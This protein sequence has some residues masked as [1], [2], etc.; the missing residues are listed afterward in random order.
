MGPSCRFRRAMVVALLGVVV[1]AAPSLAVAHPLGLT[2]RGEVASAVTPVTDV[3]FSTAA[4][5][6][7][8]VA[9]SGG[10]V[11]R[12]STQPVTF[13]VSPAMT[14]GSFALWLKNTATN[15]L[16]RITPVATPIAAVPA[17][18]TYTVSWK[19]TQAV[20]SYRLL[21]NYYA[22]DGLTVL[23]SAQSADPLLIALAPQPLDIAPA[24]GSVTRGSQQRVSWRMPSPGV[25]S[26]GFAL[27]LKNAATNALTRVTPVAGLI[28]AQA[29][30]TS[31]E[32]TW[33]ASQAAADYYLVVNYYASDR[34][35]QLS[36]GQAAGAVTVLPY[37]AASE[38]SP[39]SGSIARGS[40][41]KVTW[42]M[43]ATT[44]SGFCRLYLKN[45]AT[46]ALTLVTPTASPVTIVPGQASY[47][48]T[49][50]V[51]QAAADYRLQVSYYAAGTST[52]LSSTL[53]T[54]TVTVAPPPQPTLTAP[55]DTAV[56]K[57]SPQTVTWSVPSPGASAGFYALFLKNAA[58]SALT[59]LTPTTSLIPAT[60]GQTSYE[61][62]WTATQ[63]LGASYYLVVYYYAADRV[64]V[65]TT[66][67]SANAYTLIAPTVTAPTG[68]VARGTT[69]SVTWTLPGSGT[70]AGSFRVALK[71]AATNGVTL[72][73]S[74]ANAVKAT[75]R[76]TSYSAPWPVT[77]ALGSSYYLLVYYYAANGTTLLCTGQSAAPVT[78]AATSGPTHVSGTIS[79]DTTWTSAGSPYIVDGA[80]SVE[81]SVT[82]TLAPGTVVKFA[83]SSSGGSGGLELMP[84]ARLVA[85]GTAAAKVYLTSTLD[86][87]VGGDTDGEAVDPAGKGWRGIGLRDRSSVELAYTVVRYSAGFGNRELIWY[88]PAGSSDGR[89][90]PSCV[91]HHCE[92]AGNSGIT[93]G[94]G[95]MGSWPYRFDL[96]Q[97]DA[98]SIHDNQGGI[99]CP[100]GVTTL[101]CTD[102][103]FRDNTETA[104]SAIACGT[105]TVS[106]CRFEGNGTVSGPGAAALQL[107][108][109][110]DLTSASLSGN[111][112]TGNGMAASI[113]AV[114]LPDW[115]DNTVS[116]IGRSNAVELTQGTV[117]AD[118]TLTADHPWVVAT[119]S[120]VRYGT[121]AVAEGVTLT[122][123]PGTVVKFASSSSGGSGGLELMPGA[124]LVAAGTAAA[125][126]YLTST[127]DDSVGGDTDGEAVDPAGKGWRGIG[128]RDRSSV[129][130]AYTVVRYSAGFGNRELIWYGPAGSSDGRPGP[131]CVFHHCEFAGNSGITS[132]GG[133]MGSW[134]YRFDLV[135]L[136]ACSIHDNQ[137]GIS[138]PGGVTTLSCTDSVFRDN[139]ETALSAIACGTATVSGCRFEGNGTALDFSQ[140]WIAAIVFGN[141]IVGN[142]F[143]IRSGGYDPL[144]VAKNNWWGTDS[145]P[146][147]WG[148][149]NGISW[150]VEYDSWRRAYA[151][152][153][154]DVDPWIGKS[155]AVMPNFGRV[156]W[157][158]YA[159]DPVNV[160]IGNYTYTASDVSIRTRGLP[161]E[162]L[163][164][165]NS[166]M[167]QD[168]P[169]GYGWAFSYGQRLLVDEAAEVVV[170]VREDGRELTY[171]DD[172]DGT[173]TPPAGVFDTLIQH[174]DGSYALT[175]KEQ[176]LFAF[177]R[178]GVLTSMRDR[179]G[180]E[181]SLTYN[182]DGH[183]TAV[184]APD[185]RTL[186]LAHDNAG[187]VTSVT[188][189]LGRVWA[190]AYSAAGDLESVTDPMGGLTQ[191]DYDVSHRLLSLTDANG[192]VVVTNTY[193]ANGRV[194]TQGD[195]RGEATTYTYDLGTR[196]TYVRDALGGTTSYVYD[197]E[198][199]VVSKT[200]PLGATTTTDYN[201]Q[202]L[203]TKLTDA[204]G[205]ATRYAYDD[206][207]NLVST[208][209]AAGDTAFATYN[210]T[211]DPLT[212]TDFI[213]YSW[214]FDYDS[215]G[216][217]T[218][219]TDQLGRSA[220]FTYNNEGEA[221][222]STDSLG[223]TTSY[224]W[225]VSG[226][227]LS[228]LTPL[229]ARTG[230]AY[231]AAGRCTA[232]TDPTGEVW[233]N[234]YDANDRLTST[235]D[236]L[237]N[238]T[239][240]AYDA[241]GNCIASTDAMG[242][243]TRYAYDERNDVVKVTDALSAETGY[244]YDA[245][246]RLCC[247]T[248]ANTDTTVYAYDADGRRTSATDPL[249][250]AYSTEYDPAGN[251]TTI[252]DAMGRTTRYSYDSLDHVTT[253]DKPGETEVSF[254]YDADGRKLTTTDARGT[255]IRS[256][257]AMG[258]L[259]AVAA[260][261]G[262]TISYEY[263][264]VGERSSL[265]YPDGRQTHY[266]FDDD[267]RLISAR[268]PSGDDTT[269]TYRT[270]GSLLNQVLPNGVN[271]SYDY[272]SAGRL[273][274]IV[275]Q[276]GT[277]TLLA[278]EYTRD[279][280]G[281]PTV[282]GDSRIGETDYAYDAA[283]RLISES[284][285]SDSTVYGY[286]S[287]GHRL[288]KTVGGV[289][290]SST[291]D[292]AGELL[293]SGAASYVYDANGSRTSRSGGSGDATYGYNSDGLLD[294]LSYEG[295]SESYIYD[296]ENR[297][298]ATLEGDK[299]TGFVLDEGTNPYAV[300]VE[301]AGSSSVTY[302]Y[303]LGLVSQ[304]TSGSVRYFLTDG[305]GSVRLVT[306][307]NG[308]VTADYAYDAF[309][310]ELSGQD[311][312]AY[313]YRYTG[314]S[315]ERGELTYLRARFYEPET[316]L[317][318]SADPLS[319]AGGSTGVYSY[320]GNSPLSAVD[321]T[322]LMTWREYGRS[323][324]NYNNDVELIQG[325]PAIDRAIGIDSAM[326]DIA[327][328]YIDQIEYVHRDP[329]PSRQAMR[330]IENF[331]GAVTT[332]AGGADPTGAIGQLR[333]HPFTDNAYS[334]QGGYLDTISAA[335]TY[336]GDIIGWLWGPEMNAFLGDSSG[337]R[338]AST[339]EP[340]HFQP[341]VIGKPFFYIGQK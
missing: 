308:A 212:R 74:A 237:G 7:T 66:A 116:G 108:S 160:T 181:T 105:A 119:N 20:G 211:N 286:D 265:T 209:N 201:D 168:S 298:V 264:S 9:P 21:V 31:Y 247:V 336:D 242:G 126:V 147:P 258:H 254:T 331:A 15:A 307:E 42:K 299:R 233:S 22:A 37:P 109:T 252:T 124:R 208:T 334:G 245:L 30:Q 26:G 337:R 59:R 77:Q 83:S 113:D 89:P 118:V 146:E 204:S 267:G 198:H 197:A 102:S 5:Q 338:G 269:Y 289:T 221:L 283:G 320:C 97:L 13:S 80:V 131:S 230:Y 184:C 192:H 249:G 87:S 48:T 295:L 140:S 62:T 185:G 335:G 130:L 149:S 296:G 316:G 243:T 326:M 250:R 238:T 78:V 8:L 99:S 257:D 179:H 306:D 297:R 47:E 43:P 268:G 330:A 18:T 203:K 69:Q 218:R 256:Y 28:P 324:R 189:V 172:G 246:R 51:T 263:D 40:V 58:T 281:N 46:N 291:Y 94:G 259:I 173:F 293:T 91:F 79:S 248:D 143:G 23:A 194:A 61:S 96:V 14:S 104:L 294:F 169:F 303:G 54:G 141:K 106:G 41:Q 164:S 333:N 282:I 93:S 121:V 73:T 151:V 202:N 152:L 16:T 85:A 95:G 187:H 171:A 304:E 84:G 82:L 6:L 75:E 32:T 24:G 111:T 35:T 134:P 273:T 210:S 120:Y 196:T 98:C 206:R 271:G 311:P 138:C 317:F 223:R 219:Q 27:F 193:D 112:F 227:L 228:V 232:I 11:Y 33:T 327:N 322:G 4:V 178:A 163:R 329:D 287:V 76:R 135:Q 128:L 339:L 214:H 100:G 274:S 266:T 302:T 125:K 215:G 60:A 2:A 115:N 158:E 220:S 162:I 12:N 170:V 205:H 123:A 341:Y 315:A 200:S 260:P 136:D 1:L 175:S 114:F 50:S 64:S 290:T 251:V 310:N 103:V 65:L 67:Q 241:V 36:S 153:D 29:T 55:A 88:G 137:G 318:L 150:H 165:Y 144:V 127:L 240:R 292:A 217:L 225:D 139:T 155:R 309:G 3:L 148:T 68:A 101:S 34:V 56:L 157:G 301:T 174:A 253:V 278:I 262:K 284:T 235:T 161:L 279:A 314:Q 183:L 332:I 272:D 321:P 234:V 71:N 207:G 188:D 57:G 280:S 159:A 300:L 216:N 129:E 236:P 226:N 19:A 53:S 182:P 270:D 323:V 190:Y 154:V 305:L 177:S 199:R 72:V 229:G 261:D 122:L 166:L 276:K 110:S 44:G 312:D 176:T 275:W 117:K 39:S 133:G 180:N 86:D 45:A 38:I 285:S 340:P 92:F 325:L 90:G 145:G 313:R 132:G 81:A 142:G 10:T 63:T 224:E 107:T 231:D 319:T 195:A 167:P 25:A 191:Y 70:S 255:T 156:G 186:T 49:W 239:A 288:T 17:Q 213:G 244:T 328:G 52:V 222:T 277:L